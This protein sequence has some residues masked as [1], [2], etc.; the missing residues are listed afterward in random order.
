MTPDRVIKV[1][2]WNIPNI[3]SVKAVCFMVV[4]HV[5][6]YTYVH[7]Y[8]YICTSKM[9]TVRV[10]ANMAW[11]PWSILSRMLGREEMRVLRFIVVWGWQGRVL[12]S[13]SEL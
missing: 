11:M 7:I 13:E 10:G 12:A 8:I 9:P 1:T 6:I 3:V 4:L 2:I 5:W